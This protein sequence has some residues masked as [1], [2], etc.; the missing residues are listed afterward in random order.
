MPK[1]VSANRLSDGI[2]VYLG[3]DGAWRD[4]LEEARCFDDEAEAKDGLVAAQ[5]DARRNL[6]VDPFLVAVES[7]AEGLRPI[8]L[9]NAIRARGPTIGYAAEPPRRGTHDRSRHV[10]L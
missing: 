5:D 4:T 9:R 6:V 7:G 3:A 1:L 10:S 8:T 2:V